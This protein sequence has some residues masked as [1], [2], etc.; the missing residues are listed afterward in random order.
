MIACSGL[1]KAIPEQHAIVVYTY[2]FT[3]VLAVV[4]AGLPPQH[5]EGCFANKLA[6]NCTPII[7]RSSIL[8]APISFHQAAV[9]MS[10]ING[11][12]FF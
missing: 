10:P 5:W 6:S 8:G 11:G 12:G 7:P 3:S 2:L 1:W 9:L 4:I